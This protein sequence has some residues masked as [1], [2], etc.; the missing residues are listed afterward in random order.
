MGGEAVLAVHGLSHDGRGVGRRD[1]GKTVF[2]EG[3]L[4]GE[5]VRAQLIKSSARFDEARTLEV[6]VAAPERVAPRCPHFGGCA[7]CVLQ[8]LDPAA[9]IAAKQAH[10]F[11]TLERI[12]GVTPERALA[13]LAAEPWGY[14]RRGRLSVKY[15]AK[16]GRV[17]VGFREPNGRYVADLSVCLTAAPAVGERIVDLARLIEGLE[18]RAEIPQIEFAVGDTQTAL[19]FRH[20]VPL[21][22]SDRQ[23][24]AAFARAHGVAVMLQPGGVDSVHALE[25]ATVELDYRLGA[26]DLRFAFEPL[27]FIQVNAAINA[28]MIEQA[29]ALLEISSSDRLLDLFCGLGNLTLPL[30]RRASAVT[31]VEG[32]AR[33]V[34]RAR[35]NAA[36]NGLRHVEFA[37]ADLFTDQRH[38]QWAAPR[39]DA[40]V[41]DPPRAGA[42]AVLKYLPA[43]GTDRVLYV[44]CH[45]GSLA[46]DAGTLV[47][48]HGFR[49]AAAGA[50]DMFPHTGHVE[51]MAL[52]VR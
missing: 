10:L 37:A 28:A 23:R 4:A 24:L 22:E 26:F 51:S 17:L 32:D 16:K 1:D 44:S 33:L 9:Q 39:W 45:P 8:H 38:A 41:L 14:R 47:R 29:I 43:R 13:P 3:A 46:R 42:E 25:P 34:A 35:Q 48:E 7:G 5:S 52:F 49:L 12:G 30:A 19:V 2:V 36:A 18:A 6:L 11:E 31:G 21:V 40:L 27:D 20:L 15:V 50:M